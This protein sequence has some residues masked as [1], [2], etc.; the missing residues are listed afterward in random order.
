M[1]LYDGGQREGQEAVTAYDRA[2]AELLLC[3]GELALALQ[4]EDRSYNNP[5]EWCGG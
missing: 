2:H 5:L 1:Q 4:K 3:K